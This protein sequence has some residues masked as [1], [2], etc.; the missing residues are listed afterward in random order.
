MKNKV[1]SVLFVVALVVLILTVSIGLPIYCRFFYYA[2]I[3]RLGLEVRSGFSREEIIE[4][5]DEV[6]DYLTIPGKPFGTGSMRHSADGAAHFADCKVL[7]DLNGTLLL[8]SAIAVVTLLLLRKQKKVGALRLG[9]FSASFWAA[10]TAVA[11]PLVIGILASLDFQKAFTIFHKILFPGKYNWYFDPKTDQIIRVLPMT[12]FMNCAILIGIG[13]LVIS[14]T[15]I[16]VE[17]T[18]MHKQKK[19]EKNALS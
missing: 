19:Q 7:F 10:I 18:R 12:F 11:L 13:I 15:I 4:A 3:E 2:Q 9:R 6:L 16:A 17:L 1:V 8:I 14:L 5:Y